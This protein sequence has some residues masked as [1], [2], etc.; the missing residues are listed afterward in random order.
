[1]S[2]ASQQ[3]VE[4]AATLSLQPTAESY[5]TTGLFY[6][7]LEYLAGKE[8]LIACGYSSIHLSFLQDNYQ[9]LSTASCKVK[10]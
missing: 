4:E 5:S 3:T 9:C 7:S 6:V 10:S 8:F 2:E 1:M